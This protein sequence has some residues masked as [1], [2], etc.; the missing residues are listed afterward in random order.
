MCEVRG[1]FPLRQ[2]RRKLKQRGPEHIPYASTMFKTGPSPLTTE[3][4]DPTATARPGFGF[5]IAMAIIATVTATI[6]DTHAVLF[7]RV[8]SATWVVPSHSQNIDKKLTAFRVLGSPNT[9]QIIV[10]IT[11]NTTVQDP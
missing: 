6:I 1:D 3:T 9:K 4:P 5:A 2:T 8:V 7:I 10:P 11:A